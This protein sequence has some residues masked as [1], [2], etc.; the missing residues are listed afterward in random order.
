MDIRNKVSVFMLCFCQKFKVWQKNKMSGVRAS[1]ININCFSRAGGINNIFNNT[2][3]FYLFIAPY[4]GLP[5]KTLAFI[6][7]EQ[8][9]KEMALQVK[10]V[11]EGFFDLTR[12][13]SLG[14]CSN[15][16]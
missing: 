10:W 2:S 7:D 13:P 1:V 3:T 11:K 14:S 12:I 4:S 16:T 8:G 15:G 6:Y 5:F 9:D